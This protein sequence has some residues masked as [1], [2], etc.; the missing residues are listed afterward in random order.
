MF[1]DLKLYAMVGVSVPLVKLRSENVRSENACGA[2]LYKNVNLNQMLTLNIAKYN[3][4]Q[5]NPD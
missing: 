1:S 4:T 3:P 5:N 2:I